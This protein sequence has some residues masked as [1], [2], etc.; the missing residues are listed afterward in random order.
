MNRLK[1]NALCIGF[2]ELLQGVAAT[3]DRE[4]TMLPG[5]SH[6]DC[7]LQLTHA[8]AELRSSRA[9]DLE[10]LIQ[11]LG[12]KFQQQQQLPPPHR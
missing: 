10:Y 5:T 2:H 7:A 4:C 8:A 9:T 1:R 3:F 11:P 6:P 12:T